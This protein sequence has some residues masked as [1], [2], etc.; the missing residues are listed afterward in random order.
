[1][2]GIGRLVAGIARPKFQAGRNRTRMRNRFPSAVVLAAVGLFEADA[3]FVWFSPE[4]R[5]SAS[6]EDV[7]PGIMP[8]FD[9][10]GRGCGGLRESEPRRGRRSVSINV[11]IARD[12]EIPP[13]PTTAVSEP[14]AYRTPTRQSRYRLRRQLAHL[15]R[16]QQIYRNAA[17]PAERF[18]CRYTTR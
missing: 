4:G 7:S 16:A 17:H 5:K 10:A 15:R 12:P 14:I 2:L 18:L 6:P 9:S 13:L 1:M 11:L 8:D 3:I